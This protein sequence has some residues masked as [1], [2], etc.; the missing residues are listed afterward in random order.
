MAG[1]PLTAALILA[2]PSMTQFAE[3]TQAFTSGLA[4]INEDEMTDLAAQDTNFANF[5]EAAGITLPNAL[6]LASPVLS[7]HAAALEAFSTR[8]L[9]IDQTE[10]GALADL[11]IL[12]GSVPPSERA[13]FAS[14]E[15]MVSEAGQ[16]QLESALGMDAAAE[17]VIDSAAMLTASANHLM[18]AGD[19]LYGSAAHLGS[20]TI[21][22]PGSGGSGGGVTI[23]QLADAV[24]NANVGL[25]AEG[26]IVGGGGV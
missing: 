7:R 24:N 23:R 25:G 14:S 17:A 11:G 15:M 9:D 8:G 20:L 18:G 16:A 1:I 22:I 26:G 3:A 19:A 5:V 10:S 13:D 4:T 21:P 12:P 2:T 6:G